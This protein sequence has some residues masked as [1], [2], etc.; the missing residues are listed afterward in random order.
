MH[1]ELRKLNNKEKNNPVKKWVKILNRHLTKDDKQMA[2]SHM[3][4]VQHHISLGNCKLKQQWDA[5]THLINKPKSRKLTTPNV[6]KDVEQKETH[7]LLVGMQNGTITLEDS[8][9]GSYKTKYTFTIQSSNHILWYL[10]K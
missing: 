7:S 1:K 8:L 5:T 6:N 4:D 3:K 2:N 9:A 10:P